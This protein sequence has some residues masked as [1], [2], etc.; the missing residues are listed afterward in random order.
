[1]KKFIVFANTMKKIIVFDKHYEKN[2][3]VFKHYE[4]CQINLPNTPK[5]SACTKTKKYKIQQE[6][7][8]KK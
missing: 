6:L 3:S 7:R 2:N 4:F 5:N 8:N 1:M